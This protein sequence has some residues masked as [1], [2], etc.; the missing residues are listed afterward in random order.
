MWPV[1][2]LEKKETLDLTRSAQS[3]ND[4]HFSAVPIALPSLRNNPAA[5]ATTEVWSGVMASARPRCGRSAHLWELR[6]CGNVPIRYA[7][8]G[9]QRGFWSSRTTG[10]RYMRIAQ[11]APLT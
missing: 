8:A 11:V 2:L 5:L 6:R 9:R 7:P 1:N 4:G 3:T 10:G